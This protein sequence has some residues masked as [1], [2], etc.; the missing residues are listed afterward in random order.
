MMHAEALQ[1]PNC[2]FARRLRANCHHLYELGN[3]KQM[4]ARACAAQVSEEGAHIRDAR[5]QPPFDGGSEGG[6]IRLELVTELKIVD[7]SCLSSF[8]YRN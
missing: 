4:F 3:A 5:P 7:S 1:W 6:M 8:S 2:I